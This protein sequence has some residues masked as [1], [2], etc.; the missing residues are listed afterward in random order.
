M[1]DFL[2]S[3]I[4]EYEDTLIGKRKAISAF[5]FSYG[6]S[7]NAKLALQIMRYAFETY[8]KWSPLVL[9]NYLS[10]DVL[11]RLKLK[12]LLRFIPFPPELDAKEDLF[13]I[14]WLIYPETIHYGKKDLTLRVYRN[15]LDKKI[16]KFPKEFFTGRDGITRSQICLRY[17]IEQHLNLTSVKSL[18]EYFSTE[19]CTKALRTYKL[20]TVCRDLYDSQMEYLHNSLAKE[21][22]DT[23]WF[24]YYDFALRRRLFAEKEQKNE[25]E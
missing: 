9:R 8:L 4:S 12:S 14:A 17:M 21:Q 1:I 11:E 10:H 18:Y 16:Q 20:L 3:A 25:T 15:L 6:K 7:E 19:E 13:Y 2:K 24:R 23:F 5:Y 22:R